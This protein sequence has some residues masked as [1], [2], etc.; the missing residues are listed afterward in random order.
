VASRV[1]QPTQIMWRVPGKMCEGAASHWTLYSPQS[2]AKPRLELLFCAWHDLSFS[3]HEPDSPVVHRDG[4]GSGRR[5]IALKRGGQCSARTGRLG[6]A[7]AFLDS[8]K[9]L[10]FKMR[11]CRKED[12]REFGQESLRGMGLMCVRPPG[13]LWK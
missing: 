12:M 7:G 2:N 3:H 8:L 10:P 6:S 11:S 5:H 4:A 13:K 9:M 1:S